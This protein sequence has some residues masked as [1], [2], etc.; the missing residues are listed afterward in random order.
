MLL[1]K[2]E[3][4]KYLGFNDTRFMLIGIVVL[5][6]V[7]DYMFNNSFAKYP[8]KWALFSW[9][10]SLFFADLRLAHSKRQY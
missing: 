7:T 2:E 8:L 5:S 10:I 3:R 4:I 6:F 1:N 9:S